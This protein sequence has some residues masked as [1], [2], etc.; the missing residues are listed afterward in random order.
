VRL[1][2]EIH[3]LRNLPLSVDEGENHPP[4]VPEPAG[5]GAGDG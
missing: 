2:S 4:A 5:V 1:E 3:Q